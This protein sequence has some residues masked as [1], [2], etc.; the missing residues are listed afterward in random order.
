M[1]ELEEAEKLSRK[2]NNQNTHRYWTPL[3]IFKIDNPSEREIKLESYDYVL[4]NIRYKD[5]DDYKKLVIKAFYQKMR[6][7]YKHRTGYHVSPILLYRLCLEKEEA[8]KIMEKMKR[9]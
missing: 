3:I 6:E 7:K 5:C 9:D 2:I 8:E 1:K 4:P